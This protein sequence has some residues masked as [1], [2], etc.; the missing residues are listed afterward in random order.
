METGSTVLIVVLA[1]VVLLV[2]YG[3][4]AYNG[5]VSGRNQVEAAWGQIDVQLKRRH[6]L[7]PNLVEVAKDY[8]DFEQETLQ[9]RVQGSSPCA[10]TNTFK[11]LAGDG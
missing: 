8:M 11:S 1:A 6:D 3:I 2:L 10:P 7:I 4:A 5:L 9:Q